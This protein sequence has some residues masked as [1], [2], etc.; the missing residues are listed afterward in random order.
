MTPTRRVPGQERLFALAK[1]APAKK[2]GNIEHQIAMAGI[3]EPHTEFQFAAHLGRNWAFDFAW[4]EPQLHVALEIEGGGFGRYIVIHEG[5]ERRKGQSIPIKAGTVIRVGG[6]HNTGA[7]LQ[8]D[9]E[10][11]NRA[12]ILGWL[13]IRATTTMV[14]D[15]DAIRDL[16]D[17]F[18]ARGLEV[19]DVYVERTA[20]PA[21]V[22]AAEF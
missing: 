4:P 3:P 21:M 19:R 9:A 13:V 20:K 18:R 1:T 15:G 8:A 17:A 7:G 5:H 14:R 16:V 2:F 11:Y 10:K 12:A 6:R 22:T